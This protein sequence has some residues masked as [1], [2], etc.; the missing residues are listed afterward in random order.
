MWGRKK[1]KDQ[2]AGEERAKRRGWHPFRWFR[3]M[4]RGGKIVSLLLLA[5]LVILVMRGC[6][7]VLNRQAA[8]E[9]IIRVIETYQVARQAKDEVLLYTGGLAAGE[10]AIVNAKMAAG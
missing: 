2:M 7:A 8:E 9:E 10:Q 5:V 4:G 1:V 3:G 6:G